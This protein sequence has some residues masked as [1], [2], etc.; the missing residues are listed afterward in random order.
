MNPRDKQQGF[1]SGCASTRDAPRNVEKVVG[2]AAGG[3]EVDGRVRVARGDFCPAC[4]FCW[5]RHQAAT[6]AAEPVVA[7]PVAVGHPAADLHYLVFCCARD[8]TT[9]VAQWQGR[10]SDSR[11]LRYSRTGRR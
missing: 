2:A 10:E 6:T 9:V 7:D 5:S 3:G 4:S 8:L 1:D 11:V